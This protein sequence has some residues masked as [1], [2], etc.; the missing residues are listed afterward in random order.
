[1]RNKFF[2][3][4]TIFAA[5]TAGGVFSPHKIFAHC[6]GMDGP[7]IKAAQRGLETGNINLVLIWVPKDDEAEIKKAFQ[8]TQTV[9]KLNSQARELADMYFSRRWFGFTVLV[10]ENPI[11]D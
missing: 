6:D 9:R 4:L 8:K 5:L 11:R 2:W 10:K 7:V 3:P 1:M